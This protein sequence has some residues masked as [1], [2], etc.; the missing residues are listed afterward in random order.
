MCK[1]SYDDIDAISCG[2]YGVIETISAAAA[3]FDATLSAAAE[4]IGYHASELDTIAENIP[5]SSEDAFVYVD[6]LN[7]IS[8]LKT[9][10]ED[11]HD[12]AFDATNAA[13]S[14]VNE[15]EYQNA[16]AIEPVKQLLKE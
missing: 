4:T 13:D 12:T 3:T 16:C 14:I 2:I 5:F 1:P 9:V 11:L 15:L 7:A 8:A 6:M 10:I